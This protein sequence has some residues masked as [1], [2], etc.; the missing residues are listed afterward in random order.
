MALANAPPSATLV[1]ARPEGTSS[2]STPITTLVAARPEGTLSVGLPNGNSTATTSATGANPS[3]TP[4]P[5]SDGF[6]SIA[7]EAAI[8]G[9][10]TKANT[11]TFNN[12]LGLDIE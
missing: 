6:S 7:L 12:T 4:A 11:P 10:V 1:P 5:I 9:G 8:N 3:A 2:A